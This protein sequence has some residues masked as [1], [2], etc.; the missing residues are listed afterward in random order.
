MGEGKEVLALA[1]AAEQM[2]AGQKP[3]HPELVAFKTW[4][5]VAHYAEHDPDGGDLAI[6]VRLIERYGASAVRQAIAEAVP[7]DQA[8]LVVSTAHK[9]KGREWGRVRV[10]DDWK[11]P[12]DK[13]TG[14]P[15]PIPDTLAML[16]YVTVTRAKDHLDTGGLSW[17][18]G[19]LEA[20]GAPSLDI[21]KPV[22][23]TL[24]IVP[25]LEPS[26][27]ADNLREPPVRTRKPKKPQ[28]KLATQLDQPAVGSVTITM[29]RT[30]GKP[31]V[32]TVPLSA[33]ALEALEARDWQK[34]GRLA[35]TKDEE[36][37]VPTLPASP[38]TTPGLEL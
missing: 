9:A 8:E 10:G 1:K 29:R 3:D 18:R 19:H 33:A 12:I 35:S 2:Q 38:A 31:V 37:P 14:K 20:L 22:Q 21:V 7:A 27:V 4:A 6:A 11:E 25:A 34:L 15:L 13:G 26:P 5:E 32:K 30:G 24:P 16:A 28:A 23:A 17:V 36:G